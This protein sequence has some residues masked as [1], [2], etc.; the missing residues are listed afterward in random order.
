MEASVEF[1]PPRARSANIDIPK[2]TR[3]MPRI[4]GR[5][6]VTPYEERPPREGFI[7]RYRMEYKWQG[8]TFRAHLCS[9]CPN[10]FRKRIDNCYCMEVIPIRQRLKGEEDDYWIVTN[11][12]EDS[13]DR[14]CAECGTLEETLE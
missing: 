1:I 12:P 3:Y 2:V 9:K 7:Q 8:H 6:L 14:A 11:V 10:K 4:M 5:T 13:P